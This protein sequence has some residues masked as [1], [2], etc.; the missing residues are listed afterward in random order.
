MPDRVTTISPRSA[1]EGWGEAQGLRWSEAA[2]FI[3]FGFGYTAS[4]V[5]SEVGDGATFEFD[6]LAQPQQG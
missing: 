1:D 2:L 5:V 6:A 3:Y 4:K